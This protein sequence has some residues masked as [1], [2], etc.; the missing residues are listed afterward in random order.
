M[1]ARAVAARFGREGDYDPD[2]EV[3]KAGTDRKAWAA[4]DNPSDDDDQAG[5]NWSSPLLSHF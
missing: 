5:K 1:C 2:K 4:K 3:K